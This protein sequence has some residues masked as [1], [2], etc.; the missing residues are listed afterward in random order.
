MPIWDVG[1]ARESLIRGAP[2]PALSW[3]LLTLPRSS[4]RLLGRMVSA[5]STPTVF[6]PE[7]ARAWRPLP[8]FLRAPGK[9]RSGEQALLDQGVA[10][11]RGR[12]QVSQSLFRKDVA[13]T[14][15]RS[16]L[17]DTQSVPRGSAG[18]VCVRAQWRV[19]GR[20]P[21]SLGP[22]ASLVAASFQGSG[23]SSSPTPSQRFPC[24]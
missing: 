13:V 24:C 15:R 19:R 12:S 5:Q 9:L 8:W 22:R 1:I 18:G 16:A 23:R 10:G 21:G 4:S 7:P 20:K 3:S 11:R 17:Q 14:G 6:L 2:A